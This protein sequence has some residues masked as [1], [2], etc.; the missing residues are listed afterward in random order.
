VSKGELHLPWHER[1]QFVPLSIPSFQRLVT[2][3]EVEA[4]DGNLLV[5][6]R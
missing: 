6:A 3:K 2:R 1:L 5:L 4:R